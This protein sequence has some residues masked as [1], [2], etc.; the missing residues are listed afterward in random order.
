M[1]PGRTVIGHLR[2]A[3]TFALFVAFA[4]GGVV[5]SLLALAF[6]GNRRIG[7]GA[8]RGAWRL[9]VAVIRLTGLISVD[10]SALKKVRGRIIVANHP[11]LIDVVLLTAFMP[12]V[13]SIAKN[14]LKRNPFFGAVVRNIML[15]NDGQILDRARKI[16]A[17]GG[18]VLIFPEG[19]RTPLDGARLKL[20]R[21]AAQLAI[22]LGVPISPVRIELSRRI[23]AKHQSILDMG[24]S[25]VVFRLISGDDIAP[26]PYSEVNN[27]T[28]AIAM[29]EAIAKA[30][31][32][33]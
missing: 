11:S 2:S 6:S 21:G 16:L 30:I 14:E 29:T 7:Q 24:D 17:G 33:I 12:D 32:L 18:N 23:L 4:A 13:Y 28:G 1:R 20:H 26:P 22:R 19:T 9:L 27:R 5:L 25:T 15:A 31:N 10:V 8:V 3:L